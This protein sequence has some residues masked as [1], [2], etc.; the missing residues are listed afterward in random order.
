MDSFIVALPERDPEKTI[1]YIGV[2]IDL[3]VQGEWLNVL[4]Y[5]ESLVLFSWGYTIVTLV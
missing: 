5:V 3:V 2:A 4:I 1:V